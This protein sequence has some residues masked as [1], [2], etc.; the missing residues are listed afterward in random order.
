MKLS[1]VP[2]AILLGGCV[3][4]SD[5]DTFIQGTVYE[6]FLAMNPRGLIPVEACN[7][8]LSIGNITTRNAIGLSNSTEICSIERFSFDA[9]AYLSLTET[10]NWF[11]RKLTEQSVIVSGSEEIAYVPEECNLLM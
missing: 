9:W 8:R 5:G 7:S 3:F 4:T 1:I 6:Y 2:L 11:C 10:G